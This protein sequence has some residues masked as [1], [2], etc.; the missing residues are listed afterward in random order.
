MYESL[1]CPRSYLRADRNPAQSFNGLSQRA[2][3]GGVAP[4]YP[5]KSFSWI[6]RASLLRRRPVFAA[7]VA[8]DVHGFGPG[9]LTSAPWDYLSL[10][11]F[12]DTPCAHRSRTANS[13]SPVRM[14]CAI[15]RG[16]QHTP[17]I[18]AGRPVVEVAADVGPRIRPGEPWSRRTHDPG[19]RETSTRSGSCVEI[20]VSRIRLRA[21][22]SRR[23]P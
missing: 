4:R 7:C 9:A 13:G 19:R 16:E 5:Y 20:V 15:G 11:E 6:F 22:S 2:R 23:H 17:F 8:C 10:S 14:P 3:L 21:R 18:R 12:A 1:L